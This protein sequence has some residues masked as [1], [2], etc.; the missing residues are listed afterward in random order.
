MRYD[1]YYN[2]RKV[3]R[4]SE[5]TNGI[6]YTPDPDTS[7][8]NAVNG[9]LFLQEITGKQVTFVYPNKQ[10]LLLMKLYKREC[11]RNQRSKS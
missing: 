9:A 10:H 3:G 11:S 6:E 1:C 7:L 5:T 8:P 2:K 4:Y